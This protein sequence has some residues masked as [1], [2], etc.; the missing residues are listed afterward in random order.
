MRW[1]EW[2]RRPRLTVAIPLHRAG[3]WVETVSA[4]IERIPARS[5]IVLSDET[6]AD[7]ALDR[8]AHRFRGDPRLTI[9][10][11]PGRPGWR[12]HANALISEARTELFSILPQDDA[13]SPGYYEKLVETLDRSPSAGIAFG[14]IHTVD[15]PVGADGPMAGPPFAL[16]ARVPWREALE[17]DDR[18]NLGIPWRGVIRRTVLLP[19][20]ATPGD[21]F[22]DQIWVFGMAL[23][24]HLVEVPE[25][26]Y[27]KHYHLD[28]VHGNW[29]PLAIEER[30]VA[31]RKEIFRRLG[32]R[33]AA[34]DAALK[35]LQCRSRCE[36]T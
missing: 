4:N 2:L 22:A 32:Q 35:A 17:L 7:D 30:F 6:Q 33:V 23:V 11:K 14:T 19:M 26:I 28:S 9:R 16:G 8:L 3:S 31:K 21:R 34:R 12:E 29:A 25:A 20:T 10:R 36:T 1:I 27:T 5:R 18:W 15:I 24:A 13:I